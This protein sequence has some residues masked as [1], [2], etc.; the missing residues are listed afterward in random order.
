MAIILAFITFVE[1]G[2]KYSNNKDLIR[3][4][5]KLIKNKKL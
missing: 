3:N 5:I 2:K 4:S 1:I